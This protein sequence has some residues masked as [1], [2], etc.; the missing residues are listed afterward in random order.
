[1]GKVEGEGEGEGF[2]G[3]SMLLLSDAR[4]ILTTVICAMRFVEIL[5]Y[6]SMF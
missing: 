6:V 3:R 2:L 1:M 4:F 5:C